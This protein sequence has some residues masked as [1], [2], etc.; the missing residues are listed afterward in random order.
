MIELEHN[1]SEFWFWLKPTCYHSSLALFPTLSNF[2]KIL[3]PPSL[4]H[5]KL[6]AFLPMR[7]FFDLVIKS[8]AWNSVLYLERN[9]DMCCH[10]KC[11]GKPVV[12]FQSW[13]NYLE[14]VDISSGQARNQGGNWAVG[15]KKISKALWKHQSVFYLL[16]I[17]TN[18]TIILPPPKISA[19]CG[20]GSGYLRIFRYHS[21]FYQL[22]WDVKNMLDL[23][24]SAVK[25]FQAVRTQ[26][27][28]WLQ[29]SQTS[30]Y[31]YKNV[32]T[33]VWCRWWI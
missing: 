28:K 20:L 26:I 22:R 14:N 1:V 3:L 6:K 27:N 4:H 7:C 29:S 16:C 5:D 25:Y 11:N 18:Y 17:A 15:P 24:T 9:R 13:T 31:Q 32:Y 33:V 19:G 10:L 8:C 23:N 2:F 30:A 12:I 21:T